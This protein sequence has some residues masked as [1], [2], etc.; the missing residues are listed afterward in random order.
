MIRKVHCNIY[1]SL[2]S[3]YLIRFRTKALNELRFNGRLTTIV[4]F[5]RMR[6]NRTYRRLNANQGIR[7]E[8]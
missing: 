7:N 8:A 5:E 1:M 4:Q 2:A 6:K 3:N